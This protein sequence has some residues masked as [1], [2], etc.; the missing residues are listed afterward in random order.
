MPSSKI[1][2]GHGQHMLRVGCVCGAGG[3][4]A[5]WGVRRRPISAA[6]A[7]DGNRSSSRQPPSLSLVTGQCRFRIA[8][9]SFYAAAVQR[10]QVRRAA[11]PPTYARLAD[12]QCTTV[13]LGGDSS[14]DD[15]SFFV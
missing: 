12:R 14:G 13:L 1:L 15:A 9:A 5:R 6:D 2:H 8:A 7:D 11:R 10:G 4:R 3:V